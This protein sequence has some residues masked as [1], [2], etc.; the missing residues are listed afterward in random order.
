MSEHN[1]DLLKGL[2]VGGLIG[3]ALGILYAPK[4]GKETREDIA[5]KT[6]E[7]L[8]KAK[9]EYEKAVEKSKLAYESATKRIQELELSAKEKVD[10]VE[11]KVSEFAH[12]SAEAVAENKNRLK[13][14]IDAGV[15]A[16]R[17]EKTGK[18]A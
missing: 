1:G 4:S 2:I 12:H 3:A 8:N 9:E 17:E 11:N 14:A 15:E 18:P 5:R 10:E 6:E 16:Y 13:K 7:L